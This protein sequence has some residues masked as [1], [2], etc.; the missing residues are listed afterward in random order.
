MCSQSM[1]TVFMRGCVLV[2]LSLLVAVRCG[3]VWCGVVQGGCEQSESISRPA[4][5]Q[6]RTDL[7]WSPKL[8][9][10]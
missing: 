8:C 1:S 3:V 10:R 6:A 2:A 5:T 4:L 9:Y 7:T